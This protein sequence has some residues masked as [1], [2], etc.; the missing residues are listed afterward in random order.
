[1]KIVHIVSQN[2]SITNG[3]KTVLTNLIPEQEKLGHEV[4]VFNVHNNTS[5]LF[6]NEFHISHYSDFC[7][8]ISNEVP[9]VVLFHGGYELEF[10]GFAYYL[11][12]KSIPYL[13]V[14]HGGTSRY[15]ISKNRI[16]KI[17]VNTLLTRH[18]IRRSSGVIFLNNQERENSLFKHIINDYAIIPNGVHLPATLYSHKL[19]SNKVRFMFLSRIDIKYKGLDILLQSIEQVAENN[20]D[21][22]FEFHFYGSRYNKKVVEEFNHLVNNTHGPIFYHGEVLGEEKEK[23]YINANIY[24]LPSLS[25]GMPLT[26]LEALSYGLPCIVTPQTNMGELII[27]HHAGWVTKADIKSITNTIIT[28]YNDYIYNHEAYIRNA[29]DAVVPYDWNRIASKS[30]H[31]YLRLISMNKLI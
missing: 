28:A 25:E 6:N 9:D 22:N 23:A 8:R 15:N 19:H 20:P 3:I 12:K 14:P 27:K 4:A 26:V 2:Y 24:V 16:L 31:E 30:I 18:F 21:L 13:V 11:R 10:Y 1:M 5:Y 29:F 17:I 7:V